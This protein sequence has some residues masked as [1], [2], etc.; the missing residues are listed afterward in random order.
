LTCAIPA[1]VEFNNAS[2]IPEVLVN[3]VDGLNMPSEDEKLTRV[4]FSGTEPF[5]TFTRTFTGSPALLC[6]SG[7]SKSISR[8]KADKLRER[9]I[10]ET[11]VNLRGDF[12][13]NT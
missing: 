13:E 10:I 7:V 8:A 11:H 6:R 2:A 12:I 4:L 3:A 5:V 9:R 1:T